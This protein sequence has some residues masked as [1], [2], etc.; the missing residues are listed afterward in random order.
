MRARVQPGHAAAHDLDSQVASEH[1]KLVQVGDLELA[2][3]AGLDRLGE[4][5][6]VVVV[7]VE[8]RDRVVALGALRL[9]L[10]AGGLALLVEAYHAVALGVLDVVAEHRRAG[11]VL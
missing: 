2:A 6:H 11:V 3:G 5:D 4:G 1:V 9:L 7:E 10:E 8:A